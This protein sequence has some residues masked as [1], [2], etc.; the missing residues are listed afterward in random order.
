MGMVCLVAHFWK[1]RRTEEG[2]GG[3]R[4]F[5]GAGLIVGLVVGL[6]FW[7][8]PYALPCVCLYVYL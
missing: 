5:K 3:V 2:V 6:D 8:C 4:R 1:F 7:D